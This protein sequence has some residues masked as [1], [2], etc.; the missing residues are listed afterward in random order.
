M[1]I[2]V[3]NFKNNNM[4]SLILLF[5][6]TLFTVFLIIIIVSISTLFYPSKPCDE[7]KSYSVG[8]NINVSRNIKIGMTKEQIIKILG[9]PDSIFFSNAYWHYGTTC[10]H[11]TNNIF[12]DF[13]NNHQEDIYHHD[14]PESSN[15]AWSY[16]CEKNKI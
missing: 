15:N 4:N 2:F 5:K 10:L 9:V 8:S 12:V 1:I 11:F 16:I 7:M 3:F 13:M 14:N 6:T